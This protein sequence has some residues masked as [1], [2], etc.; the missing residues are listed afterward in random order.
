MIEEIA[1][2]KAQVTN[3][4]FFN[5]CHAISLQ[6]IVI[7]YTNF[8]NFDCD[9]KFIFFVNFTL[10]TTSILLFQRNHLFSV[11]DVYRANAK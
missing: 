9:I 8:K 6:L 2:W 11:Y 4:F 5:L 3:F 10:A 1:F 7:V